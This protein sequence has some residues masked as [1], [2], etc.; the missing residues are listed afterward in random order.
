MFKT[1]KKI[2]FSLAAIAAMVGCQ[3][4]DEP[5]VNVNNETLAL[6]LELYKQGLS[7]YQNV[8]DAQR[9]LL[10]YQ[11]YLVQ[12]QA[13]SLIYLIKLYEALGGGW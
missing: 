5:I 13:G 7:E 1:M 8:L 12:A 6:S 10:T 11:D 9:T 2:L 4:T 3:G